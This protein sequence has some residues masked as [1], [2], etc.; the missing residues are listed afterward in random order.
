MAFVKLSTGCMFVGSTQGT[1][2]QATPPTQVPPSV[3]TQLLW[4]QS[5]L[6]PMHIS[7]QQ[8]LQVQPISA[9]T[10][11][12]S[13]STASSSAVNV[14]TTVAM[15]TASGAVSCAQTPSSSTL[16]VQTSPAKSVTCPAVANQLSPSKAKSPKVKVK[17][18]RKSPSSKPA[19]VNS[20]IAKIL[21]S[22]KREMM[23]KS[24]QRQQVRDDVIYL[25]FAAH[26][27]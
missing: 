1:V 7:P 5:Q 11:S 6:S 25:V 18:T 12:V 20:T 14:A 22:A 24:S 15:A 13:S 17:K 2:Q 23:Q 3:N 16:L 4:G 27:A 8:L 10:T 21:E 26:F 19:G 9:Q